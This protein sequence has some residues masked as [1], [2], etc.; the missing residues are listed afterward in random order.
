MRLLSHVWLFAAPLTVAHQGLLPKKFSR[1]EYRNGV[2]FLTPGD[3]PD[4]GIEPTSLASPTLAGRFFITSTTWE[5]CLGSPPGIR[6][7]SDILLRWLGTGNSNKSTDFLYYL[8]FSPVRSQESNS[9][10]LL[11]SLLVM[12]NSLPP[13]GL[14]HARIPCPSLSR[15]VCWNMS[16]ES[17][18][19]FNQLILCCS[20]L[21]MLSVF[22]A[23]GSFPVSQ[24]FASDGQSIGASA[25]ASVLPMIIQNCYSLGLTG[26]IFLLS[27]GIS[28]VFYSTKV[29]KHQFFSTQPSWSSS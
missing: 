12:S 25:S 1:P 16:I 26:L 3:L 24:L 29:S 6:K 27:K 17:V 18:R 10:L 9:T 28:R 22:P 19:T 20:L 2:P 8:L 23:S 7:A 11:F 14:Q 13:H 5:A 4:P 21:H 15:R